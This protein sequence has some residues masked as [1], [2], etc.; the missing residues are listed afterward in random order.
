MFHR[1]SKLPS[2]PKFLQKKNESPV[3]KSFNKV[4]RAAG[5]AM[6]AVGKATDELAEEMGMKDKPTDI[7]QAAW[8]ELKDT[9]QDLKYEAG[10]MSKKEEVQYEVKK[11]AQ[12]IRQDLKAGAKAFFG[13]L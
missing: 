3:K 2:L 11:G 6:K 13:T 4:E 5:N 7:L 12:Q 8:N 1:K 10:L 9:T